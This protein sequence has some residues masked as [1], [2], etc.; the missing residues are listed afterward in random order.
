MDLAAHWR[1]VIRQRRRGLKPFATPEVTK[2]FRDAI[3]AR[4]RTAD[5]QWLALS[6]PGVASLANGSQLRTFEGRRWD[7]RSAR[8]L[9]D[10]I[11]REG[12]NL[13]D[14][15]ERLQ[16]AK[17]EAED[18]DLRRATNLLRAMADGADVDL[19]AAEWRSVSLTLMERGRDQLLMR[20]VVRR[21]EKYLFDRG[22]PDAVL[23]RM[24]R[25]DL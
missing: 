12:A 3:T 24:M 22:N 7:A 23:L 9:R 2:A 6:N 25:D 4:L 8:G 5:P 21:A 1:T 15:A 18:A 14:R 10:A 11:A 19:I 17:Q 16:T 20:M 13:L